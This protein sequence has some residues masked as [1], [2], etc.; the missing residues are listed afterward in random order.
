M[1]LSFV[2]LIKCP[3]RPKVFFVVDRIEFTSISNT[4]INCVETTREI[5]FQ[6]IIKLNFVH[7]MDYIKNIC[8]SLLILD[9]KFVIHQ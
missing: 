7:S 2:L 6:F 9:Y 5:F 4:R 3:E 1:H 8:Q